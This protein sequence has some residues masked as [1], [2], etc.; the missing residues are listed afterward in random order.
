MV[1]NNSLFCYS[2]DGAETLCIIMTLIETA[3]SNGCDPHTYLEY[4][5]ESSLAH[6]SVD[7]SEYID[8]MM[9]WSSEYQKFEEERFS[10]PLGKIPDFCIEEPEMPVKADVDTARAE[11][12]HAMM[13][14]N[15]NNTTF[16]PAA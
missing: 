6:A 13:T 14:E 15:I 1:R 4:L 10:R 7:M 12:R 2:I 16:R 8:E 3:K 5:F 9:R 11:R